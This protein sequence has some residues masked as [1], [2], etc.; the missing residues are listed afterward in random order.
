MQNLFANGQF[1]SVDVTALVSGNGLVSFV[2]DTSSSTVMA[3][4]SRE[5]AGLGQPVL[6]IETTG[7]TPPPPPPA[8]ATFAPV[9]DAYVDAG[10][11]SGNNGTSTKLRAD[12]SPLIRAYLRFN[13]QGLSGQRTKATLKLI[14]SSSHSGGYRVHGG[15]TDNSWNEQTITYANAPGFDLAVTGSSGSFTSEQTTSVDVTPL[16]TGDGLVTFVLDTSS[17]TALAL[18]SREAA[19]KAPVLVV[20]TA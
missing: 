5:L 9:A 2:L 8:P 3:L 18:Y 1:R 13:V 7:S 14:S 12:G 19:G 16:V 4:R 15:V 20:E 11:P 10:F 6:E 17:S